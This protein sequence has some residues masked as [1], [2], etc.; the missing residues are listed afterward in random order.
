MKFVYAALV[1]IATAISLK[2]EAQGWAETAME[3]A[4]AAHEQELRDDLDAQYG[5]LYEENGNG[6][7]VWDDFEA[8]R[9]RQELDYQHGWLFEDW[10]AEGDEDCEAER[11]EGS[12]EEGSDGEGSDGEG[13]DDDDDDDDGTE[14]DGTELAQWGTDDGTSGWDQEAYEQTLRDD[15]DAQYGWLYEEKGNGDYIWDEFEAA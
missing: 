10:C 5:W 3:D 1:G 15:L 4:Q 14:G 8:E 13:S 2:A 9:M 7:Y 6:K 12:D 11:A